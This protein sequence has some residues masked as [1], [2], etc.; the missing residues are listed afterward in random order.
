M[1][2]PDV[3]LFELQRRAGTDPRL[4]WALRTLFHALRPEI[5]HTHAWGTLLEG[6]VAAR[7]ARVPVVVHG[8]HGTLQVRAHQRWLQRQGWSRAEQVLS[9]STRLAERM[10][11]EIGFPLGRI[12]VIRNGVDLLRFARVSRAAARVTLD[13]PGDTLVVGAVG[14]LV[15]VKDHASLVEA[16]AL[17]RREGLAPAIVIAGDGPLRRGDRVRGDG[18]LRPALGVGGPVEYDSRSHGLCEARRGE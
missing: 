4:V 14:R 16:A 8:E 1:L 5:V 13:L 11:R 17:L 6:L 12:G 2:A 15:P 10:S 9:V 18:C 3:P 7:L